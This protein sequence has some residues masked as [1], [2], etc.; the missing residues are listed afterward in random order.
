MN[1]GDDERSYLDS[2]QLI[3]PVLTVIENETK[4]ND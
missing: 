3:Q 1:G 2:E 4:Q